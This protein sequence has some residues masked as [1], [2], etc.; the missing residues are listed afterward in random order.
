M[1]LLQDEYRYVV[2]DAEAGME[3]ISRGTVGIPDILLIVSDPGARGLRTAARIHE[4]AGEIGF[5]DEQQYLVFNRYRT[6][7]ADVPT[8]SL[9]TLARI[10]DDPAVETA[11]LAGE[12]IVSIPAESPARREVRQLAGTVMRICREKKKG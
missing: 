6:G 10:P 3:H 1:Q 4:I 8:G 5:S 7:T 12:P 11:D 9:R 2:I